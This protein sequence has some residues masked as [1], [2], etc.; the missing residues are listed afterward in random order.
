MAATVRRYPITELSRTE[1]MG[2]ANELDLIARL[3]ADPH[4]TAKVDDIVIE[5]ANSR[6]QA[7]LDRY[8]AGGN[9]P[10][11]RL[12]A[13]WRKTTQIF[14]CEA[15]PTTKMLIDLVR[16]YNLKNP[17]HQLRVLA[18]DPPIDWSTVHTSAEFEK[19]LDKRDRN[20][21]SVI[22]SQVLARHRRA[23][24]V[25]GGYHFTR[26]ATPEQ[27][28]SITMLLE[29]SYPGS[30]YVIYDIENVSRFSAA[31]RQIFASWPAPVIVPITGTELAVQ[32]AR[33]ITSSDT[34]RHVGSR[35]VPVDDAFPGH[36]L[37]QLFDAILYL[38]PAN[39]LRTIEFKEP[40]DQPYA[41]EL[42]RLRAIVMGTPQPT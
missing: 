16:N 3:L 12:G 34:M 18:A 5:C 33:T 20:A 21:A 41:S 38:G 4:F 35:W 26:W 6:Y 7:M 42:K 31:L 39:K 37:G 19:F 36:T 27:G 28:T 29:R 40:A 23:L 25:I 30:T 9:V 24:V 14:G 2:N 17:Q 1:G 8:I 11:Q 22:E 32:S 15:D 13:V 10:E